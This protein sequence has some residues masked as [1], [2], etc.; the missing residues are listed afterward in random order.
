MAILKIKGLR[1]RLEV[2]NDIAAPLKKE[3]DIRQGD[4]SKSDPW[5]NIPHKD[6]VWGGRMSEVLQV[7]IYNE[8][9]VKQ[10]DPWE[11]YDKPITPEDME[12]G[13]KRMA[14]LREHM[15]NLKNGMSVTN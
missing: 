9:E 5:I 15:K 10:K 7:L 12:R 2:I 13:R 11:E 1:E 6:G 14:E 8:Q 3:I 4:F